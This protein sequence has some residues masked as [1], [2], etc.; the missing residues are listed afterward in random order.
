MADHSSILACSDRLRLCAAV[1][2]GGKTFALQSCRI[3]LERPM[4]AFP[5]ETPAS[6]ASA[7]AIEAAGVVRVPWID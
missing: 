3:I 4:A 7:A 6:P 1:F 5:G 2:C